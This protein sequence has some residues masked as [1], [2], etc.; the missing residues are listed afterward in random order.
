M[1]IL[2][3]AGLFIISILVISHLSI[4][5]F[6]VSKTLNILVDKESHNGVV[7]NVE[8]NDYCQMNFYTVKYGYNNF[9]YYIEN[10]TSLDSNYKIGDTIVVYTKK[11]NP[12]YGSV[13]LYESCRFETY[14]F[15]FNLCLCACY[16]YLLFRTF[17]KNAL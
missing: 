9:F 4:F 12:E 6:R 15:V 3:K 2:E 7:E 13:D 8:Y 11:G 16:F 1:T 5:L 17:K 14:G 10:T